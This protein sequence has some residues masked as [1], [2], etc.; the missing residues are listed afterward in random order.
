MSVF[1][2]R[3][4]EK[5]VGVGGEDPRTEASIE[6]GRQACELIVEGMTRKA[7]QLLKRAGWK[8]R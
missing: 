6:T 2:G 1:L 5:L 4:K 8:K 7:R 3:E